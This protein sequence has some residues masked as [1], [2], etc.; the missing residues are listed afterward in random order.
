MR[1]RRPASK[2]FTLVELLV[3]VAI[4][5]IIAAIAVPAL[6]RG[7]MA[8]NEASAIG[9]VRAINAAETAYATSAAR[10]GFAI[11]LSTLQTPCGGTGAGFLS[12][13]LSFDP[14]FKSG[15]IVTLQSGAGSTAGPTD[16]NGTPTRSGYYASAT[17]RVIGATGQRAFA[18]NN[19][20]AVWQDTTGVAPAEPFAVTPTIGPIQ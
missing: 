18:S 9:S 15:Y 6:L 13:D 5:G 14:S 1:A 8:G 4:I 17:P 16:C 11:L 3:A 12:G 20:N 2:G 7:K 10:G 19:V